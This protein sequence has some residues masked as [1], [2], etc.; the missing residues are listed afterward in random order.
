[1]VAERICEVEV[2]LSPAACGVENM[3]EMFWDDV[4]VLC[5]KIRTEKFYRNSEI[6]R[7][8][9]AWNLFSVI[10]VTNCISNV[11]LLFFYIC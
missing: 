11:L 7:I 4:F 1:M 8:R 6:T 2:P 9:K 3:W 10:I 5:K